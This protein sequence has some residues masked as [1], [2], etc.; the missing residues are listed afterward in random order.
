M[1]ACLCLTSFMFVT[2][3]GKSETPNVDKP[4]VE[5]IG[6]DNDIVENMSGEGTT[7]QTDGN[8][9]STDAD[10][11]V[12]Y[13][14]DVA[15]DAKEN[16]SYLNRLTDEDQLALS[17]EIIETAGKNAIVVDPNL[18]TKGLNFEVPEGFFVDKELG[19]SDL[20]VTDRYPLDA[21][22]IKY[23][24]VDQ[25]PFLQLMTEDEFIELT[26]TTYKS[27][28]GEDIDI[29]VE[30][31]KELVID[32]I[33]ALRIKC[34]YTAKNVNLT[35]LEYVINAD[36]TYILIY[37]MTSDY[38]RMDLFEESAKTIHVER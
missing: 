34:T 21:T 27:Q 23:T 22:N 12:E 14:N 6:E 15:S 25:D 19:D 4:E 8:E 30:E 11:N 7:E 29:T 2:A 1:I 26:K 28:Y 16:Q 20:Y 18:I 35:Q 17:K 36:K 9:N 10:E 31:Y 37:T 24:V 3:C 32:N 13:E 38:D 5:S 33:P